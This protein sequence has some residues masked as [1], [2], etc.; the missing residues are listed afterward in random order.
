MDRQL[1]DHEGFNEGHDHNLTEDDTDVCLN[2][3]ETKASQEACEEE[4][5]EE[6]FTNLAYVLWKSVNHYFPDLNM[7][8]NEMSDSRNPELITYEAKTLIWVGL[9]MFITKRESRK[10]IRDQMRLP[11]FLAILKEYCQQ[12]NLKSVPHDDTMKY[13]FVRMDPGEFEE[14]QSKMM[15]LLFR[16]KV[17]E[18]FKLLGKYYTIAIDGVHT[19][20]FDYE[21]CPGCL[22]KK[23]KLGKKSWYHYK[24]E[25]VLVCPNGM[26]LSLGSEWVENKDGQTK[27]DCELNATYRLLKKLRR[28]YPKLPMCL[29]L[30]SLFCCEPMFQALEAQRMEWMVV[31]KKGSM[32][33]VFD[34]A[35]KQIDREGGFKTHKVEERKQIPVRNPRTHEE[36]LTR[37][38]PTN[39]TREVA[40]KGE[41]FWAK[42]VAHWNNERKYNVVKG[43][44]TYDDQVK[45]NYTW[46]V[47]KKITQAL[48]NHTVK[49]VVDH[50]GRCRW[51]IENEGNNIQKNGG[52][53]LKH[54]YIKDPVG[55]KIM[56]TLL[57]MSHAINQL[58]EKGSLI[59]RETYGSIRDI[60]MYLF[61]HMRYRTFQKPQK[62]RR[63]QIRLT[64][65][66]S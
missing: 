15:S 59:L 25:A 49:E 36:L 23:D 56:H 22:F 19:G 27:Q 44:V 65:D 64:W 51:K 39:E 43:K 16:K 50:G 54:C 6:D 63:I 45:C 13:L 11:E 55:M 48:N 26:S 66:T 57:D 14:L 10:K 18:R 34:W 47:S 28:F 35:M 5:T 58:I 46:L 21:H 20:S 3:E 17:L 38:K 41:Y 24:V 30:D 33:E 40:F 60:A 9:I 62:P 42:D 32:P 61:E 52:Y 8:M 31:F 4:G 29:L 37:K 12:E 7:W 1:L 53:N 2:A